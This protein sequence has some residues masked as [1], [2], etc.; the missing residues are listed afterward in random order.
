MSGGTTDSDP[1]DYLRSPITSFEWTALLLG[2][3][4]YQTLTNPT[5]APSAPAVL[6]L[7]VFAIGAVLARRSRSVVYSLL[8]IALAL[9]VIAYVQIVADGAHD[10]QSTRDTAVELGAAAFLRGENPWSVPL[11]VPLTT[12][13]VSILLAVPF[14]A[15]FG[16]INWLSCGFWF[17]LFGLL[18]WFD[19]RSESST[20]PALVVL[21]LL[22]VLDFD[23]TLYWSLEEF[24]YPVVYL[25]VAYG[26]ATRSRWMGV[27]A[28]LAAAVLTRPNYLLQALAFAWWCAQ[29]DAPGRWRQLALIAVGFILASALI[30]APFV[31]IGGGQFVADN[32]WCTALQFS[33]GAWPDFN[34]LYRGLNELAANFGIAAAQA[35]KLSIA[36]GAIVAATAT[37][38]SVAH[39]FWHLAIV[40]LIAHTFVWVPPWPHAA[41]DYSLIFVL[42]AMFGVAMTSLRDFEPEA[43]RAGRD[44]H[45]RTRPAAGAR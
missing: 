23:Y 11:G 31:W 12:G 18:L 24:Y 38:R 43:V 17:A 5:P 37:L 9:H 40:G 15:V 29:K 25:A 34:P 21:F 41:K 36:L 13:P 3:A 1:K 16:E 39:P 19:V 6:F 22:G 44:H 35:L 45:A 10:P 4:I 30:L 27:G 28:C 33:A 20:W 8:A 42:P 26:L 32:P 7:E 14:V 2:A